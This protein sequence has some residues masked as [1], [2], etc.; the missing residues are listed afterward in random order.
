MQAPEP[1]SLP[2][3]ATPWYGWEAEEADHG[4]LLTYVDVLSVILAMLVVL[5]GRMV[6]EYLP[7][8]QQTAAAS[9]SRPATTI[10]EPLRTSGK[11]KPR[12]VDRP[13]AE[14]SR[15]Q[16]FKALVER[17]FPGQINAVHEERGVS[18]EIADVI[19]FASARAELQPSA[20]P[21]LA[22]LAATL[23]E[24]GEAEIAVEGHTDSRPLRGGPYSSNWDLAAARANA[25][26][27]FLLRQGLA[28][29]RL[30][31]ISY[32]DTRPVADNASS[33]GRAANRRVALRV[34]FLVD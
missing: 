12:A 1:N 22:R 6:F 14:P 17:R 33:A 10:S 18:L 2:A 25:V 7:A 21:L 31:A 24:M 19:L 27:E 8:T 23:V 32:G 16:R 3:D 13:S 29:E 4:W 20:Q 11:D 34:E 9:A 30:R 15:E 5:M 26:T 28:A